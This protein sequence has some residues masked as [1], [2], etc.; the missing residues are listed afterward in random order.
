MAYLDGS[1]RLVGALWKQDL[2]QRVLDY[3]DAPPS[4]CEAALSNYR[5]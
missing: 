2:F 4:V 5:R 1:D 3:D